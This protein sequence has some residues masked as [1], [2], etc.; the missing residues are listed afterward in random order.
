MNSEQEYMLTELFKRLGKFDTLNYGFGNSVL[1]ALSR[2]DR[3]RAALLKHVTELKGQVA[4]LMEA[5]V[6]LSG[7]KAEIDTEALIAAVV[8]AA[9][10][11]A[12]TITAEDVAEKL[13]VKTKE[14]ANG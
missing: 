1:P 9:H 7:S 11:G 6:R 4:G 5:V 10:E 12:A 13:T 3:D 8:K 14:N 2:L